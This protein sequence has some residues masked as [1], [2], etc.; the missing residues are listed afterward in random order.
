MSVGS[1]PLTRGKPW[2]LRARQNDPGLIPTHAGKTG[3]PSVLPKEE[4]AH[5]HSRGEN[6]SS[7]TR[8]PSRRGSSPLTRGKHENVNLHVLGGR[9]IP[10]H[11]GKTPFQA[12]RTFT[13]SA[14]P[15]SRGE[16]ACPC[17]RLGSL[18]GS[19]P[20]TRGKLRRVAGVE[21]ACR[22]IPAHAGKTLLRGPSDASAP[23]HP[24]SRGENRVGEGRRRLPLGS[25]PL[26]RGKRR[27]RPT[28]SGNPRL[29]PAH[30]GKT[31]SVTVV[32]ASSAAHPR[33]RGE[34]IVS[35]SPLPSPRWLIPA[36]AGKTIFF[37]L[38][39]GFREAHP[40]SRGENWTA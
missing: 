16:N 1:S 20:L 17:D 8:P 35:V 22:L 37:K 7:W 31:G 24:R 11:A 36:H 10:A 12:L 18:E 39:Q 13:A 25:S 40:R 34:N 15:R 28:S 30:A 26:T 6:A 32:S 21:T 33:S 9:L 5:P 38:C 19:S 29:I 3:V 27:A 2:A 14:H 23:A 4:W